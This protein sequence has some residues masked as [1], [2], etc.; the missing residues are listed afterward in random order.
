MRQF[1]QIDKK[2]KEEM[3]RSQGRKR[4]SRH[5]EKGMMPTLGRSPRVSTPKARSAMEGFLH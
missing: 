3:K 1:L 4:Q 5:L 2:A